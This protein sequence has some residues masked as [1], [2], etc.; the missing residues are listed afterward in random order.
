MSDFHQ[1]GV[2]TT[3]HRLGAPDLA[4]LERQL[5]S[6]SRARPI[7]LVLP[8]LFS[9]IRGPGLKGIVDALRGVRYLRQVVVSLSGRERA[10]YDEMRTF[11]GPHLNGDLRSCSERRPARSIPS[12]GSATRAS[13]PAATAR[14]AA[15]G[16]PTATSSRPTCRA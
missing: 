11:E 16:S 2:I 4:R 9:E 13:T 3:L 14:G 8:C 12:S 15:P 6:Y 10:D 5:L 7:A 1:S